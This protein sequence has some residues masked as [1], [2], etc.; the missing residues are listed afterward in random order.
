M[1]IETR[2]TS[3]TRENGLLCHTGFLELIQFFSTQNE[4]ISPLKP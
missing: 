2:D 1:H 3:Q 4:V